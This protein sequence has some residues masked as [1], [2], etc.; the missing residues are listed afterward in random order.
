MDQL[1]IAKI[2]KS[3]VK[4]C[5]TNKCAVKAY[6]G[7]FETKEER[8]K[9]ATR[10]NDPQNSGTGYIFISNLTNLNVLFQSFDE[11]SRE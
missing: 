1:P 10:I 9:H 11:D 7:P 2:H 6:Y 3:F 5:L 8:K 4:R